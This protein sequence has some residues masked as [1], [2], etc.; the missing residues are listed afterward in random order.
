MSP[1]L[2]GRT[3]S[4]SK[5][6]GEAPLE[7]TEITHT[8]G[9]GRAVPWREHRSFVE[10]T[11]PALDVHEARVKRCIDLLG[12]SVALVLLS[13]LLVLLAVL[14]KLDSPGPVVFTQT[15]AGFGGRSFRMLKLR[16]MHDGAEHQ[17][18]SVLHLSHTDDT[19]LF[20]IHSDPRA[21]RLGVI[22]R[23]WSLDELPQLINVLR[24]EMS[25]VGPRPFVA[26]DLDDYEAH[27]FR[28]FAVKPGITG[29]WQVSGRSDIVDFEEVVRLDR[30]YAEHWSP[31]LDLQILARTVPAVVGRRGAY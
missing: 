28:R 4:S 31:V 29:L 27:H 6:F 12:A 3:V 21:T 8:V 7:E 14:V 23:R 18:A 11:P 25:L 16:T 26:S 5:S 10:A 22:M 30:Y 15:R 19:R 17:K 13:P 20:K 1:Y 24:G 2:S 9:R